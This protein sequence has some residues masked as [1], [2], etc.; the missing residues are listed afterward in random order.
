MV[1]IMVHSRVT[2]K[3]DGRIVE[4]LVRD[5]GEEMHASVILDGFHIV[6]EVGWLR[7]FALVIVSKRAFALRS[8][9]Y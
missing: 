7:I 1:G 3:C 8:E 9:C 2:A 5:A 4:C 6:L